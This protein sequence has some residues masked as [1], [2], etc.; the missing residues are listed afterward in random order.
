MDFIHNIASSRLVEISIDFDDILTHIYAESAWHTMSHPEL[1]TLTADNAKLLEQRIGEGVTDLKTRFAGFLAFV[2]V[3]PNTDNENI[4]LAFK[5]SQK[6]PPTLPDALHNAIV[7]LLASYAL[8]RSYE[9]GDG[10]KGLYGTAWRKYRAQ[11]A[12]LLARATM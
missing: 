3:N 7:S 5:L 2:N 12:L 6:Y 11:A 10:D 4:F 8:M 1:M 9:V